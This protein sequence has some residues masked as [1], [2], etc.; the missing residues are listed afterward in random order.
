MNIKLRG[1]I[2]NF[3]KS[4]EGRVGLK[5]PLAL[6]IA[7]GSVLL[8]QAVLSPSAYSYPRGSDECYSDSDCPRGESC[9]RE[10]KYGEIQNGTCTGKWVYEC[11]DS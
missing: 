5:T 8:A 6:G 2:K 10:C 4:E 7:S 1:K 3:L 11:T 9:E